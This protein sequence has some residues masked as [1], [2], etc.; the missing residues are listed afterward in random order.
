MEVIYEDNETLVLNKPAGIVVNR[1]ESVQGETVQD[2]LVNYLKL[3]GDEGKLMSS[4]SGLAHR[5]DRETSGCLL[6]GKNEAVLEDLLKQFKNRE[7]EKEYLAL[8]HGKLEIREGG[9]SLPIGRDIFD[10]QKRDVR[11]EGKKAETYWRVEGYYDGYSLVR[12]FPRTGRTHQIRVHM[13]HLGHPLFGDALYLNKKKRTVD[14]EK[15]ARHFLHA[16]KITF[17]NPVMGKRLTVE[18]ALPE[19]LMRILSDFDT[20][21]KDEKK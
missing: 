16:S 9:L 8:V 17:A 15:L 13:A 14:R 12:L 18:S 11:V 10:R 21:V 2:W 7:V 3:T 5:L 1:A 6:I 20:V 4:R 19:E